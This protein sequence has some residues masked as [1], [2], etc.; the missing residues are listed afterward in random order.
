MTHYIITENQR[1]HIIAA[2]DAITKMYPE[3]HGAAQQLIIITGV[4]TSCATDPQSE[5]PK[6]YTRHSEYGICARCVHC[7]ES[8][9]S[10]ACGPCVRSAIASHKRINW[11]PR[12]P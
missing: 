2:C 7:D 4:M 5:T 3:D 6:G 1:Q 9:Q 11:Q 12:T 10:D 8:I